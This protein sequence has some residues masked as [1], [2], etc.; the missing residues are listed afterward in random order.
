MTENERCLG[1]GTS[2]PCPHRHG[3]ELD[4]KANAQPTP[5]QREAAG[6]DGFALGPPACAALHAVGEPVT[7]DG[8]VDDFEH[9]VAAMQFSL[10]DG[11]TWTTY[12]TR[13]V[14]ADKGVNWHFTYTPPHPGR[15][16]LKARAIDGEGN[17]SAL[18]ASYAFEV[19]P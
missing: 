5:E 16:L 10:D 8:Y 18:V 15:Y 1:A 11:A 3:A 4:P 6:K 2:I 9:N 19:R 17:A 13:G 12:E 7:F 14:M